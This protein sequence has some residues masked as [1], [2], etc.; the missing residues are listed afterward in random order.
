M[1]L[2]VYM[3]KEP[4]A[5]GF[6]EFASPN[7]VETYPSARFSASPSSWGG[8][9]PQEFTVS[10]SLSKLRIWEVNTVLHSVNYCM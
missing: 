4:V 9:E 2:D 10:S 8:R 3:Y 1:H 7:A 6:N 5:S